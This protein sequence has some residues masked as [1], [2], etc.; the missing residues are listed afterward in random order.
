MQ[1]EST[2]NQNTSQNGSRSSQKECK[3]VKAHFSKCTEGCVFLEGNAPSQALRTS[4]KWGFQWSGQTEKDQTAEL[5]QSRR[6]GRREK[7][8]SLKELEVKNAFHPP[9][10]PHPS[11]S[12]SS[13]KLHVYTPAMANGLLNVDLKA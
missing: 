7:Y 12:L 1:I 10:P 5:S 2:G 8:R 3:E 4:P 13:P 9:P 11:L 6:W